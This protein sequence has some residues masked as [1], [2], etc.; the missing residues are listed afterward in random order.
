MHPQRVVRHASS[1]ADTIFTVGGKLQQSLIYQCDV[2]IRKDLC[3][4]V[5]LSGNTTIFQGTDERV[6]LAPNCTIDLASSDGL[7][8]M[9]VDNDR[10]GQLSVS[11]LAVH[12][13]IEGTSL[14]AQVH[15][16]S[17]WHSHCHYSS[18]GGLLALSWS[19][20]CRSL[21]QHDCVRWC[22]HLLHCAVLS[23]CWSGR[24][25]VRSSTAR[26]LTSFCLFCSRMVLFQ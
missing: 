10:L 12:T 3:A 26:C 23:A 18:Q 16:S 24:K 25:R 4:S 7:A 13:F 20:T 1:R 19:P 9:K 21:Q 2:D 5:V 22:H 17:L 8:S 15:L 14:G 6:T 11:A